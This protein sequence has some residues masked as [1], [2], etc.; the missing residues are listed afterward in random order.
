MDSMEYSW[1]M[2]GCTPICHARLREGVSDQQS[3]APAK[4]HCF[5][6]LQTNE[7]IHA[8]KKMIR[9]T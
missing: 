9:K 4:C 3:E 5:R 1:N 7:F 2:N 8:G 6:S